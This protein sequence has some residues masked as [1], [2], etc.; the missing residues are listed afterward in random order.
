MPNSRSMSEVQKWRLWSNKSAAPGTRLPVFTNINKIKGAGAPPPPWT[1]TPRR[2]WW[3]PDRFWSGPPKPP[4]SLLLVASN[5]SQFLTSACKATPWAGRVGRFGV[6][7]QFACVMCHVKIKI[8]HICKYF[9]IVWYQFQLSTCVARCNLKSSTVGC[10]GDRGR[11]LLRAP[12]QSN[13][14]RSHPFEPVL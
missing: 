5:H 2:Q 13:P 14:G 10:P 8:K 6:N 1:P 4:L 11:S 12:V 9:D 3:K 7:G